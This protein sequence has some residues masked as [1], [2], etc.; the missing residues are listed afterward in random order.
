M[1][2]DA[3]TKDVEVFDLLKAVAAEMVEHPEETDV[4]PLACFV[5]GFYLKQGT[6]VVDERHAIPEENIV[7]Q[8]KQKILPRI[9]SDL[10][11]QLL[12]EHSCLANRV[13]SQGL[14]HKHIK[15]RVVDDGVEVV[16]L[17]FF[18][19]NNNLNV[20][21]LTLHCVAKI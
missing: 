3:E 11:S 6:G 19:D 20:V 10:L 8:Q 7:I 2:S 4:C 18:P 13:V 5:V 17:L 1:S 21:L 12:G 16:I 15:G 9:G 14:H